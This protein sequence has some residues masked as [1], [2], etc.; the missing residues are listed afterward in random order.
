MEILLENCTQNFDQWKA[1]KAGKI[2]ASLAYDAADIDEFSDPVKAW[3]D[4]MGMRE[5][6]EDNESM[7]WG[8]RLEDVVA[9]EFAERYVT[10]HPG[11]EV[12]LHKGDCLVQHPKIP[13]MVCTPDYFVDINGERCI[14]QCKTTRAELL[15]S[16]EEGACP[17]RV[18]AQEL[19]EL[20][21]IP[22]VNRAFAACFIYAPTYR[23]VEIERQSEFISALEE[24]EAAFYKY[25]EQKTPPPLKIGTPEVYR[26]LFWEPSGETM[27][28]DPQTGDA[29]NQLCSK[30]ESSN[31]LAKEHEEQK[32]AAS[33]GVMAICGTFK[34]AMTDQFKISVVRSEFPELDEKRLKEK[35]PA[36][37]AALLADYGKTTRRIYPR[38][39]KLAKDNG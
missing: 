26:A 31:A 16:W 4:I 21:C 19:H 9:V 32:K 33:S 20:A 25:Y 8:R 39:T 1:L 13:W 7:Y 36:L 3:L 18:R 12:K 29:L 24:R 10:D 6:L 2:G 15:S 38:I 34:K 37:Y 11:A 5:E 35:D 17:N 27:P 14:L 28:Y 23:Y 30:Y 22:E